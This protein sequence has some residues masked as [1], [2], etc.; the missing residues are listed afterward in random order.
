MKANLKGRGRF[1][2]AAEPDGAAGRG[3][4]TRGTPDIEFAVVG[5]LAKVQISQGRIQA[6]RNLLENLRTKFSDNGETRFLPNIDAALCRVMLHERCGRRGRLAGK[7]A[8]HDN[9]RLRALWR[10]QYLTL[11]MVQLANGEYSEALMVL[12]R[13]LP[14]CEYCGRVMDGIHIRL[15]MALCHYRRGDAVWNERC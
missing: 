8:P 7:R 2:T 15:L 1:R 3:I 10:Y 11:A 13:L 14:Y 4:Q 12:A 9:V 6:A 5:L